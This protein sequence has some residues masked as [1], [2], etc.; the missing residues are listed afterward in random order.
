MREAFLTGCYC[1][2]QPHE[3]VSHEQV[4]IP[5]SLTPN[6][7]IEWFPVEVS[8]QLEKGILAANVEV[9]LGLTELKVMHAKW[10]LEPYNYLC[11]QNEIIH[12][13]ATKLY[14][15]HYSCV[16]KSVF[17][18]FSFGKIDFFVSLSFLCFLPVLNWK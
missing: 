7:Y 11:R 2:T 5:R 17:S 6:K 13:A 18:T 9:S 16:V 4:S 1:S 3:Q 15:T 12:K 14:F 10:I 8:Q